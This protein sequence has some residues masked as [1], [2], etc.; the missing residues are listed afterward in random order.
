[1]SLN[2]NKEGD[3]ISSVDPYSTSNS[4]L[5]PQPAEPTEKTSLIRSGKIVIS[6]WHLI[7]L[8]TIQLASLVALLVSTVII[9]VMMSN[10]KSDHVESE[11]R[12]GKLEQNMDQLENDFHESLSEQT[13]NIL[14]VLSN[15]VDEL[16]LRLKEL[17]Y[18][19]ANEYS[20]RMIDVESGFKLWHLCRK[21]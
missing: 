20:T 13:L 7:L 21:L 15:R 3:Y 1:M 17:N 18:T 2:T 11:N 19:C 10:M 14:S 9:G 4:E 5:Q 6:L 12:T 16:D 8:I